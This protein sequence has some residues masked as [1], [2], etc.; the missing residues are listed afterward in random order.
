MFD[1]LSQPETSI[2]ES[3]SWVETITRVTQEED[4]RIDEP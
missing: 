1:S 2:W 3:I 4:I